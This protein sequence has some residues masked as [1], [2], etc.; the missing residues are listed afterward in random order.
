MVQETV[1]ALASKHIQATGRAVDVGQAEAIQSWIAA[2]TSELG[3]LD[4]VVCNVSGF[5]TTLDDA[6]WQQSFTVDMMGSVQ[7]IE[8]AL[9]YLERFQAASIVLIAS[10]GAVESFAAFGAVRPYDAMKAAQIAYGSHLS[11]A[12]AA[13]PAVFS[14]N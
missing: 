6:G 1:T 8:A 12:L 11:N 9:P 10:V 5:G 14:C 13:K 2:L 3:G 4:I 7:T